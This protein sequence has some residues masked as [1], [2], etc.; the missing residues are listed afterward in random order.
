MF[1]VDFWASW[2]GPCRRE[3]PNIVAAYEKFHDKGFDVFGVSLDRDH[4]KWL[5][6]IEN[7]QLTW[8]HVSDLQFWNS[9]AGKLYGVNSIPHSVLISPEG[10]IVAKNLREEELHTKLG[11]YLN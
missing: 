11:E 4:A 3:N 7:D 9:A 1:L 2:C 8:N 6:A 10:I 5:E